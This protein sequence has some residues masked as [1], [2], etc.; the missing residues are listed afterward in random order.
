[1]PDT[2]GSKKKEVKSESIFHLKLIR[3]KSFVLL[4]SGLSISTFGDAFF[5]IA[6][7]WLVYT[8]TESILQT[9]FVQIVWQLSDILFAPI[10]GVLADRFD[11]KR[12]MIVTNLLA[13]L[14]VGVTALLAFTYST[15]SPILVL[16]SIFLLNS[17]TTFL[18]PAQ[19]SLIPMFVEK[20][21]LT[22][23]SGTLSSMRNVAALTGS[24]AAGVIIAT[25]GTAWAIAANALSFLVVAGCVVAM[26]IPKQTYSPSSSTQPSWLRD[27][28]EGWNAVMSQPIIRVIV[29]LSLLV[30]VA[31]FL[32]PLY[33]ALI[34]EKLDA[35]ATAYGALET[36]AIIGGILGGVAA[37]PIER[38]VGAGRVLIGG[39]FVAGMCTV[40]MGA[41]SLLPLTLVLQA[42]MVFGLTAGGVS[43]SALTQGL[44][45]QTYLG[46][47][48]GLITSLSVVAIPLSTFVGGWM[49]DL[50]GVTALFTIGGLWIVA[51]A[52]LA[53]AS[54]PVRSAQLTSISGS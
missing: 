35:N 43:L 9:A 31:S 8:Q 25:F 18:N 20:E 26:D 5:N 49:A 14:V 17:L 6:V 38:R 48:A 50:V 30:N 1:M 45:P 16:V 3:N 53:L 27:I 11:R 47:A 10:A 15:L 41:S 19:F 29:W 23:A 52:A 33:P 2:S 22:S 12:I 21:L 46:R 44:I 7:I 24:A 13:A 32:G 42:L 51:V 36:V 4:S 54:R 28:A 39:W 40:G 34:I 37:G